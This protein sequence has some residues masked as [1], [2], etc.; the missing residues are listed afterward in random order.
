MTLG[1]KKFLSTQK[2]V[3]IEEKTKDTLDIIRIKR[4]YFSKVTI[5]E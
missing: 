5:E 2:A 4:V 1:L 3:T